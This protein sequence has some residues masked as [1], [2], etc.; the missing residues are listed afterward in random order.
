MGIR[1][2]DSDAH[3]P[4][5]CWIRHVDFKRGSIP[6]KRSQD[7]EDRRSQKRKAKAY[8]MLK[9]RRLVQRATKR[10]RKGEEA[11]LSSSQPSEAAAASS[12]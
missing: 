9:A 4:V 2:G 3:Y 1:E 11:A 7:A 10:E 5:Q 12:A 8:E 6:D